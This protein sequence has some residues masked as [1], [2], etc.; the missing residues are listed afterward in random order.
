MHQH[1]EIK[2][3]PYLWLS[4]SHPNSEGTWSTNKTPPF[5][6][7]KLSESPNE[8]PRPPYKWSLGGAGG[9]KPLAQLGPTM[10]PSGSPGRK[11]MVF[12]KLFLDHLGC[13]NK[14]FQGIL[15]PWW[16]CLGHGK[17]QNAL[18]VGRFKVRNGSKLGSETHVP[19]R[20]PRPYEMLKQVLLA[21]FKPK[22]T[23]FGPWKI[24][25]AF[26][27]GHGPTKG[28]S[29]MGENSFYEN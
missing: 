25:K 14:C 22:I 27:I 8:M 29:K 3:G 5:V 1:P 13:S 9:H 26:P 6:V 12:S 15:S 11:K 23:P 18:R 2:H 19:K 28:K 4:G 21:P 7:Q 10:G 20:D 16:H 17:S 24:L